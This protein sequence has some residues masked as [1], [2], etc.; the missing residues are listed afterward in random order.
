MVMP[1]FAIIMNANKA[2]ELLFDLVAQ[3]PPEQWD[4]RLADLAGMDEDLHRR[5][6]LL[7]QAHRKADS[8]LESP[9]PGL[10]QPADAPAPLESPGVVIGAYKL[11]EQI[12]EGGFGV[13][14]VAEQQEPIR[15]KVALKAA[16]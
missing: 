8:F 16:S 4:A 7:L 5:V 13:V 6:S 9:A 2:R 3:V 14:F 15:R 11:L 10:S 1:R 12:G